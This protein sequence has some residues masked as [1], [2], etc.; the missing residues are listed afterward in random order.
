MPF[1]SKAQ[2]RAAFSGR[3]EGFSKKKAH[4]WARES[5]PFEQLPEKVKKSEFL[6][7]FC[8]D[9]ALIGMP[10]GSPAQLG[11]LGSEAAGQDRKSVV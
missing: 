1:T 3:I 9:A 7:A 8:K 2:W 4:E 5:P 11:A 6:G 10:G